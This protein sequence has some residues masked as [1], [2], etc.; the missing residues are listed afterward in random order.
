MTPNRQSPAYAHF[1]RRPIVSQ[2]REVLVADPPPASN[3]S[4]RP[5]PEDTP[6]TECPLPAYQERI[7]PDQPPWEL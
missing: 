4:R 7:N 6:N 1:A 3:R 5:V 2:P